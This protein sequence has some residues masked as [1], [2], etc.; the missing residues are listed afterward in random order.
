MSE[1]NTWSTTQKNRI[2][3]EKEIESNKDNDINGNQRMYPL[4]LY[5]DSSLVDMPIYNI[6]IGLVRFNFRNGRLAK[7]IAHHC[8][9]N[10]IDDFDQ[11]IPEH[12]KIIQGILLNA[13]N[14]GQDKVA[15][16]EE[17][18]L[19]AGQKYPALITTSG[20]LWNGNRRCAVM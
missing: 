19:K 12:Q 3:D 14:Y 5:D 20:V 15:S 18:L 2:K 1:E 7:F 13:K 9:K 11:S 10:N 16:L 4:E 17:N 6:D 8:M